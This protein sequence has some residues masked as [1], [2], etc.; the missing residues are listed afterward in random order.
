MIPPTSIDGTDITGASIDGTDVQEITVDG[1]TVFSAQTLPVAYSN[2]I[3]WYPFD[4][5]TYGGSNADDVTAIIGGSGDDTAFDGTVNGASYQ[6]SGGVT[7]INGGANSGS[8][9]FNGSSHIELVPFP[10][11]DLDAPNTV[12]F[13]AK[14]D[15]INNR[16]IIM[17][18]GNDTSIDPG[19]F[20]DYVGSDYRLFLRMDQGGGGGITAPNTLTSGTY[21]HLAAAYDGTD[22][23]LHVDGV[24]ETTGNVSNQSLQNVDNAAIGTYIQDGSPVLSFDG[25]IDD[26]RV[27]DTNLSTSQINQIYNNAGP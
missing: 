3:A 9:S 27:Y 10:T 25:D 24:L 5:A 8:F 4:S 18:F 7:D 19:Y 13:W 15:N 17:A 1:Q 16:T 21:V 14:I 20:M 11:V 23:R 12:M 2:L 22:Y 26:F 6:S